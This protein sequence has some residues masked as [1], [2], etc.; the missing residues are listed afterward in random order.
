[1]QLIFEQLFGGDGTPDT[2]VDLIEF[3]PDNNDLRYIDEVVDGVAEHAAELD[4]LIA[5]CLR[6][7]TLARISKVD[8]AI[9]RLAVYEFT[10]TGLP[11][12]VAINE[13]VELTRKFSSEESCAFI[14]GVLG[15]I[16][17]KQAKPE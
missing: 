14:N 3:Q 17:R 16:H 12:P 11:V 10:Y 4:A 1:M 13:A 9:L 7:W 2:L 6:G 15:S 5:S 8:H